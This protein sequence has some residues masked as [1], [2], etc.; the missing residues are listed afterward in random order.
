MSKVQMKQTSTAAEANT[1]GFQ[2]S[3]L[4]SM[5]W[6][7]TWAGLVL[8]VLLYFMFVTG[9]VG[10]FNREV[11]RWMQPEMPALAG[12]VPQ[13]KMVELALQR[14]QQTTPSAKE[15]YV[16][17]PATTGRG[18]P[19]LEVWSEPLPAAD[20]KSVEGKSEYLDPRTGQKIAQARETGGGDALYRMHY[21]LH[22]IPYEVAIY[23]VG[24]ATMFMLIAIVSGIVVHKKIFKDFFTFRP[25]KGQRSWLDAHNLSSVLALPFMVMITYSGLLFYTYEYMPS[26]KAAL[27]GTNESAKKQFE[28]DVY[29]ERYAPPVLANV[30]APLAPI[31]PM[32]AAA[33][34]AWGPRSVGSVSIM[35]PGNANAKIRIDRSDVHAGLSRRSNDALLFAGSTGAPLPL[36]KEEKMAA[37]AFSQAMFALHEGH[38]ATPVLRW[39]YFLTGALGA[40]MVATG[41]V[42]WTTKRRQQLKTGEPAEFGLR[43][44]ERLNVGTIVGL[45]IA[46]AIYFWANRLLPIGLADRAAWEMNTLFIAWGACLIHSALRPSSRA[47]FEQLS[48][49]ALLY[50]LLPILNAITTDKHLLSTLRAGDW[51]LA[52]FDMTSLALGMLFT[53]AAWKQHRKRLRLKP[54]ER[55]TLNEVHAVSSSK[56]AA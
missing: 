40:A 24:I 48:L 22:Y 2:G 54:A 21:T 17:L 36:P 30:S 31:A 42:L 14:L 32:L 4:Q 51:V 6:L 19:L 12:N 53:T 43:F 5:S 44:V 34:A 41:M 38:F 29:G 16:S 10:Y 27:Y 52:S 1:R 39:I 50:T 20:G 26:P 7:H 8:G 11:D 25:A 15:W 56:A 23:I 47:W 28:K 13:A 55:N 3:F 33:E 18:N 45:L 37:Q 49:A 46:I 35:Y 9:T